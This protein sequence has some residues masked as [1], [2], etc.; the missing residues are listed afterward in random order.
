MAALILAMLVY[1]SLARVP[2]C[3]VPTLLII[4]DMTLLPNNGDTLGK[5]VL[6]VHL[7]IEAVAFCFD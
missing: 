3:A 7:V 1:T 2:V 4:R 6:I 5:D